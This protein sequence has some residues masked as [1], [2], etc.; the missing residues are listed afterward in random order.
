MFVFNNWNDKGVND[1]REKVSKKF[2]K[3]S[4]E[5]LCIPKQKKRGYK[6]SANEVKEVIH[7]QN[8]I[9]FIQNM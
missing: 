6:I 3:D 4:V 1:N 8:F 5:K 2:N 7:Q 9:C